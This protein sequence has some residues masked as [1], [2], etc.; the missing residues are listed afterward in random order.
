VQMLLCSLVHGTLRDWR[1][2]TRARYRDE[3]QSDEHSGIKE[4]TQMLRLNRWRI[5][6]SGVSYWHN[7]ANRTLDTGTSML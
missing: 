2:G 3:E 5:S 4:K 7:K 6:N 1:D